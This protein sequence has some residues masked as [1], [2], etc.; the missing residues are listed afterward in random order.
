MLIDMCFESVYTTRLVS[1][2]YYEQITG[3]E[4]SM[5]NANSQQL[6]DMLK[7]VVPSGDL[8]EL[9]SQKED[10]AESLE[11]LGRGSEADQYLDAINEGV[12]AIERERP[13]EAQQ[14]WALEAI[15]LPKYRPVVDVINDSFDKPEDPWTHFGS[16]Q[17]KRNIVAA[18]PSIGRIELPKHPSL[19][20]GGT[21]FVVGDNL[22]MTNRH[23]AEIFATGLGQK[24]LAFKQGL[25][26]AID[27]IQ[28]IKPR[29]STP[30]NVKKVL[31]IHPY[32]DMAIL[33][34]EGLQPDHPKLKLNVEKP[35]SL[36][37]RDI[38]VVGYPAQDPRNDLALQMQIFR[39]KFNV[40]RMQPGKLKARERITDGFNN[41]V[42]PLTHDAS[43]LGGN[44]GSAVVDADTGEVVGLH[45]SG[46]Y[47]KAN[48]C[49]PTYELVAT[50]EWSPWA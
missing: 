41:L 9:P 35:E 10:F 13:L 37:D 46:R 20:Y 49:V 11:S 21:G 32:W 2:E 19:P 29:T 6:I 39:Q 34:V 30:L 12:D 23:V 48:Y 50:R 42:L 5:A 45:F 25:S 1:F 16:G 24:S 43:T 14:Q 36:V 22:I 17:R 40:K 44:S 7:Q 4:T 38:A 8:R 28:E 47:L 31:M 27:F 18:I 15:V 3:S 26:S 33:E